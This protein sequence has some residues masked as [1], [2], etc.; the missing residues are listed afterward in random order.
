MANKPG[1]ANCFKGNNI[2][3]AKIPVVLLLSDLKEF[4]F[5]EY[6]LTDSMLF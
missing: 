6:G 5:P 1:S 2:Q 3:P 4:L